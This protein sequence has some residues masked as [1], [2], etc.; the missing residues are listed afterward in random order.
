MSEEVDRRG[1]IKAGAALGAIGA[2]AVVDRYFRPQAIMV[3]EEVAEVADWL[4]NTMYH[5]EL[6]IQEIGYLAGQVDVLWGNREGNQISIFNFP[7]QEDDFV[8]KFEPFTDDE[9]HQLDFS[10]PDQPITVRFPQLVRGE[11]THNVI[12]PNELWLKLPSFLRGTRTGNNGLSVVQA[13]AYLPFIMSG[14]VIPSTPDMVFLTPGGVQQHQAE[15]GKIF[16]L[17][18]DQPYIS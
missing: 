8:Q 6:S 5:E 16:I 17:G 10:Y 14:Q 7:F 2:L 11:G 9:G 4:S 18:T 3:K 1:F 15:L 12:T 13:D